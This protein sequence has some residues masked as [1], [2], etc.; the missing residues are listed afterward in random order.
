MAPAEKGWI[1]AFVVIF[2]ML[3]ASSLYQAVTGDGAETER[4]SRVKEYLSVIETNRSKQE[5]N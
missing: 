3:Q 4:S 5:D 1:L 2:G